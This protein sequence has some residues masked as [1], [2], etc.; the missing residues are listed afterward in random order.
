MRHTFRMGGIALILFAALYFAS[1]AFASPLAGLQDGDNPA[2][3]LE[4]IRQHSDFYFLSGIASV[5]AAIALLGAVFSIAET[6]P[7]PAAALTMKVTSTLGLIAA[8]FFFAHGVLRIQSPGTLLYMDG[9]DHAWGLSAYLAVQMAGTQ[10]LASAGIFAFSGWAIGLSL[11]GWRSRKFPLALSVIG[12]L[13]AMPW[14]MGL[15]GRVGNLPDGLWLVYIFSI[16]LGLPLWCLI[17]GVV[18]WRWKAAA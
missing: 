18:L 13:P 17:F 1:F 4:F 14:L 2:S 10:G 12:F 9:L 7:P 8:A 15:L 5:L 11:A 16:I 3:S 6:V